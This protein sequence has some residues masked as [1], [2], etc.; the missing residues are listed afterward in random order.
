MNY[1]KDRYMKKIK[2]N[3]MFVFISS[4]FLILIIS[5]IISSNLAKIIYG[6][7]IYSNRDESFFVEN[8]NIV[9]MVDVDN[10]EKIS[11]S[12]V[13]LFQGG[14]F[15]DLDNAEDFKGEL[16]HK[17]LATVVNDGKYEK[18]FIGV[19]SGNN[20]LDMV[21]IFKSHNIQFVKQIY[22]IPLD[23]AYGSEI[24]NII[25]QFSNF[26]IDNYE[27]LFENAINISSFKEEVKNIKPNYGSVGFYNE[28]N[29]FKEL[30]LEFEDNVYVHELESIL[31]FLYYGFKQ[32]K[33]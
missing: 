1:R 22:K 4:S 5:I 15:T 24:V 3:D 25:E 18:I 12:S 23:I 9:E 27:D 31:D 33:F 26:I 10:V 20:F 7:T 16:Q 14:V 28:F 19:S 21:S 11:K 32:Y 6:N 2:S 30:I 8:E 29:S 17:T 13:I